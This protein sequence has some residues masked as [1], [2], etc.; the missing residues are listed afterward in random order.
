M[1]LLNPG[2]PSEW[3]LPDCLSTLPQQVW[4]KLAVFRYFWEMARVLTDRKY[5]QVSKSLPLMQKTEIDISVSLKERHKRK[6][7]WIIRPQRIHTGCSDHR[8]SS[9]NQPQNAEPQET[10]QLNFCGSQKY[11]F[12][13]EGIELYHSLS[14]HS[15]NFPQLQLC[16]W[17]CCNCWGRLPHFSYMHMHLCVC[18]QPVPSNIFFFP[19]DFPGR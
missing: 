1:I 19:H 14:G 10:K 6:V 18:L 11:L 12:L 2:F 9:T 3:V 16:S 13:A 15:E 5:G 8:K 7:N 17:M 4:N